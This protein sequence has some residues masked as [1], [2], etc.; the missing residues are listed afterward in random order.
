[1]AIARIAGDEKYYLQH[2]H[3]LRTNFNTAAGQA[4]LGLQKLAKKLKLN[5][6]VALTE[7][8]ADSFGQ[9]NLPEATEILQ[10]IIKEIPTEKLDTT[11]RFILE[12]CAYNLAEFGGTRIEFILLSLHTIDT[13]LQ[14][15]DT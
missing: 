12:Q 14:Q 1:M 11:L 4:V 9:G 13:A 15:I 2:W 3:A 6:F 7:Q 5:S 8:C 10:H